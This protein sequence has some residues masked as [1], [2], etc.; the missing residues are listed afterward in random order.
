MSANI[1]RT[2]LLVLNLGV[3]AIGRSLQAQA[4]IPI[5]HGATSESIELSYHLQEIKRNE[6]GQYEMVGTIRGERQ[7]E[8]RVEFGFDYGSSGQPGRALV[9]A[10]WVV[11]AEPASESFEARLRGTA[12][13]VSGQTHLEGT[14]TDGSGKGQPVETSS[15]LLN[16]GPNGS[17]SDIDGRMVITGGAGR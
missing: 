5:V 10:H 6:V 8:A 12:D 17:L 15:R 9:H 7:G 2:T 14:I 1:L 11:R 4:A 16:F 3:L 13:L